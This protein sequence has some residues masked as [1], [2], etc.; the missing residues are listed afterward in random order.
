[1]FLPSMTIK[2]EFKGK[3]EYIEPGYGIMESVLIFSVVITQTKT[4]SVHR[5]K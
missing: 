2:L 3:F 4:M 5:R 1:M